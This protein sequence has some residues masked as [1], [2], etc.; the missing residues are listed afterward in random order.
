MFLRPPEWHFLPPLL[1]DSRDPKEP[2]VCD[3][4]FIGIM[5]NVLGLQVFVHNAF[6]VQITHSLYWKDK[7]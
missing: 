7:Q 2:E 1:N 3:H 6:S 5:K 4:D